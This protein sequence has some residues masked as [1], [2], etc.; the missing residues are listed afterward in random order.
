M[1]ASVSIEKLRRRHD[2]G[3]DC[4]ESCCYHFRSCRCRCVISWKGYDRIRLCIGAAEACSALGFQIGLHGLTVP[5]QTQFEL[6]AMIAH[7][8]LI[9]VR[10]NRVF[11]KYY[12]ICKVHVA[13]FHFLPSTISVMGY[14]SLHMMSAF[15]PPYRFDNIKRS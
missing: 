11:N 14:H 7:C 10:R 12:S 15:F 8:G 2:G 6:S 4:R 9:A 1:G 3:C 5:A 13:E